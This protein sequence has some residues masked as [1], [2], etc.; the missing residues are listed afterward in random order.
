[1]LKVEHLLTEKVS[2]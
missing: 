2:T 1:M